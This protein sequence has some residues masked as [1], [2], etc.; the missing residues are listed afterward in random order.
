MYIILNLYVY[1]CFVIMLYIQ[2]TYNIR[3]YK[4]AI[5]TKSVKKI[6]KT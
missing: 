4:I 6:N 2:Y 1:T 5:L 3:K